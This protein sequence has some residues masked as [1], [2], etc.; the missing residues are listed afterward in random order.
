LLS[1]HGVIMLAIATDPDIKV[2]ELA[3][4]LGVSARTA[5]RHLT[6]LEAAGVLS[7]VREGNRNRY[8]LHR[9]AAAD[10]RIPGLTVDGF[11]KR[12]TA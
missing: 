1:V 10:A 3:E 7:R 12:L 9:G 6:R 8:R 2:A 11:L 4:Q 5:R